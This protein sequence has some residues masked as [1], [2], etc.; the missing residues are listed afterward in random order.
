MRTF[1]AFIVAA[2]SRTSCERCQRGRCCQHGL[3]I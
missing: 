2:F 1:Y 3:F